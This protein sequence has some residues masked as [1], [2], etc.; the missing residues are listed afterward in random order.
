M[1]L[2]SVTIDDPPHFP[3]VSEGSWSYDRSSRSLDQES[4]PKKKKVQQTYTSAKHLLSG[5]KVPSSLQTKSAK[6][7]GSG[8]VKAAKLYAWVALQT[9]PEEMVISP[10]LLDF[11]EKA[12]ET[13][14]ITPIERNYTAI[15]SQDEDMGQ[16]DSVDQ[17]EVS[18]TSLVSSST[19]AYS[20]FPVDVVVYVRVQPSQIKF[21]C[22]PMSRVECMLKLPSL[23]LVFSSN[24]GEL[25]TPATTHTADGGPPAGPTTPLVQNELKTAGN[26]GP[27]PGLGSPLGRT[28]HSSSQSDL[29]SSNASSSGL[30]FTA[31]M[32]D[33]SL[34]VFH[35]YGAGKQTSAVAGHPGSGQLGAMDE[36]TSSVTGR[37]DSLSIN[38]EFVKVSLSRMRR[39]GGAVFIESMVPG[40]GGKFETTLINISAS[41]PATPDSVEGV[42]QHLSPESTRKAYCRTWDQTSQSASYQ[43]RPQSP[44]VFSKHAQ[45]N[46]MSPGAISHSLKS[47]AV[48]RS[49]S[50]SDSSAPRASGPATPDSVEGVNQHLSPESTRKAYCRTWNQTSQSASYQHRPQSP[51]VF[52]EHAQNN[53]MSPG[54]ISHSLKSPAVSRSRSVSDSS[55]PRDSIAKT[56]TPSFNKANKTASQQASPWETLVVF[57]INLKQLNVQMN[58]SN[59]MGNNTWTTSGLKSQGRLSVGSN[60]DREISMSVGLGRSKLDSKGGVV[61]GNID[62]NT[63]EMV[64]L[65]KIGMK[66]QEF[67]TQQFDT[68]KRALSTWGPVP[69]MPP[70]APVINVGKGSDEQCSSDDSTYIVQTLD[71]NLGHNTMV[72]KPC[73]ALESPMATITKITRQRHENP[74]HGVASVTEWFN[75]V[76]AMRN[77]AHISEHPNQQPSHKIKITLGSTEARVDYMGSSI[78]MGIFSNADLQL[79]DEWKVNL[80]NTLE[81]SLSEK[82]MINCIKHDIL[83][84]VMDA[85]HHRHWPGVLKVI[86]GCHISLFQMPLP[87]DAVQLG[88]SMSLHGNHM[89]LACFH[90]PNFRSKSWALFHLE[91]PN[92]AF[93]T[94]AQKIWED[95]S[96]DDSTYIVQT[97]D[98]NLG[99][100][101]M[102]TKPCGA[103]ESPMAT[104][105][106]ITRQRHENPPHGVASVTEWFNYVTAM[107][108]EELNLLRNVDA[109]NTESEVAA[110]SSSLLSGFRGGLSYNHET[111]TIFALPR[112]QLD[113]KSIHVQEPEEPSLQES[114]SKPKVECSVVTEFT[115]HICVTMDAELI[116]FLHDLV[117]AYLKE[118]EK[119]SSSKPKVECSVVTEFTDHICVTMDAELIMF[120]HDLVSA[121]LKEKEKGRILTP[122]LLCYTRLISWTGRKIDPVGVDYILQKLGFHHART[123]IPKWLQRG[124]MDPLDKVLSVLI[125]KLGTTLQDEKEKKG[126]DKEEH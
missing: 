8:S 30:S 46:C 67:F 60:R 6:G 33:F 24:R 29:A 120:L 100:N 58:M 89:T 99:H 13:I 27:S 106:K 82:R 70:K 95:G 108:N 119:E 104:I 71:F 105:T 3:S 52:S 109:N 80:C 50:V 90:G 79:Q 37:K 48:S 54:A 1:D 122:S 47:P 118:K 111:E 36:E 49:R 45:N 94:E 61:G 16:F 68:S 15:S 55:A 92:I 76:T 40:K 42:N 121:Y 77:E 20:S 93:W 125:K 12:L 98:F 66:L 65:I 64:D 115:D 84:L 114:S 26:K 25:E 7:K 126:R 5:K 38:L 124:V 75:Y 88:G 43:H 62:V 73:G 19:F 14:P 56:S 112:M 31:C 51:N 117:S 28:R 101:T 21:S 72:T 11:L 102:V 57:A 59:I 41:G 10:C 113:F 91:E 4:P 32:S 39:S 69:Y 17:L 35:P 22:L 96:S 78:L 44:N 74:P 18:T 63:L 107:R 34:Y 83:F 85:A 123:T 103:L 2:L 53:C 97:L 87:E 116:M 23:D 110:K 9:L 86:A 81:T